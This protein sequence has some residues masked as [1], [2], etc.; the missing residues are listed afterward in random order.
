MNIPN[1]EETEHRKA[2]EFD[3]EWGKLEQGTVISGAI[4]KLST[5]NPSNVQDIVASQ[6]QLLASYYQ[7]ALTQSGRSFWWAL[8]GAGIGVVF[9]IAAVFLA[10]ATGH[11]VAAEIAVISGAVVEVAAGIVFFLSGKT[12]VQLSAF[13]SRLE[14]LQRYVLANSICERLPEGD[15]RNKART[16]LIRAITMT[17]ILNQSDLSIQHFLKLVSRESGSSGRRKD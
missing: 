5:A 17:T 4:S 8:A 6:L 16:D 1:P 3:T 7:I 11:A 10:L 2:V 12:W 15:E 14:T 13:L 9:F